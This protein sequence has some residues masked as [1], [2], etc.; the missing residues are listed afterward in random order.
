MD[1][2]ILALKFVYFSFYSYIGV[3][4]DTYL[5]LLPLKPKKQMDS[6]TVYDDLNIRWNNYQTGQI[7]HANPLYY[8]EV[9][10]YEIDDVLG[11]SQSPHIYKITDADKKP[12][13]IRVGNFFVEGTE[14]RE[15][16]NGLHRILK[17]YIADA[18]GDKEERSFTFIGAHDGGL[19]HKLPA[20]I[21]ELRDLQKYGSW[22]QKTELHLLKLENRK[23]KEQLIEA[24]SARQEALFENTE[25]KKQLKTQSLSV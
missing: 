17:Y 7:H 15:E 21:N 25:L 2:K 18:N 4:K 14:L 9:A 5:Y 23:L 1:G 10:P 19:V 20:I 12:C 22:K 8:I 3:L 24:E 11:S 6:Y 13:Q 16:S